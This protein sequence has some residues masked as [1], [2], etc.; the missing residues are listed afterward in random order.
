ME[1]ETFYEELSSFL[2]GLSPGPTPRPPAPTEHLVD[3]GYLDSFGLVELIMFLEKRLGIEIPLEEHDPRSFH[4]MRRM[5]DALVA[6]TAVSAAPGPTT[7]HHD[8]DTRN[9]L[10]H[11]EKAKSE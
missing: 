11:T 7:Q 2:V 8:G 3:S 9:L 1:R 4:T 6:P 10:E 5:Y